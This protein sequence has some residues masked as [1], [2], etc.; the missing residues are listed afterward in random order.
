M[1]RSYAQAAADV[2]KWSLSIP[3][4]IVA[5]AGVP[6]SGSLIALLLAQHRNIHFVE[7]EQLL[8]GERPWTERLRRNVTAKPADGPVLVV[9]DTCYTGW[10]IRQLKPSIRGNIRYGALYVGDEGRHELDYWFAVAPVW[11]HS[12]EWNLLHDAPT[13]HV[14]SDLDG[15]LCEDYLLPGEDHD[16]SEAYAKHLQ[17]ARKIRG[18]SYPVHAVV[19][20]RLEKYR[21]QTEDWLGRSGILYD[22]LIMCP[23][24]TPDE[25]SRMGFGRWKAS[26]YAELPDARLFVENDHSQAKTI[27]DLTGKAV[28]S[29]DR[30]QIIGGVDPVENPSVDSDA[31]IR[32]GVRINLGCGR[33]RIAGYV[34]VDLYC[35][36]DVVADLCQFEPSAKAADVLAVHVM[37]HLSK[38][39]AEAALCKIRNY[40]TDGGRLV[41]EMP[42]REK[43][44]TLTRSYDKALWSQGV[45]GI[46]GDRVTTSGNLDHGFI[47]WRE[48]HRA[49][50]VQRVDA[51]DFDGLCC[52]ASEF[53]RPG[54]EHRYL[55]SAGE[56]R[57]ALQSAGFGTV[58]VEAPIH[59]GRRVHRDTRWV[60]TA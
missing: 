54:Q 21:Q 57:A 39:D 11:S 30:M 60:A 13:K 34:N 46:M 8:R 18:T 9:D 55:W 19:T 6:R 42:D 25:R 12:F 40:L 36:A 15:T 26:V 52:L 4:D 29:I 5:V 44:L 56:F 22:R 20:A 1:F 23:A 43:C 58:I 28:L 14:C 27:Y 41:V 49:D 38:R 7:W 37:E 10:T 50:I 35:P 31:A 48:S 2:R 59:H 45:L 3:D 33:K 51:L 16:F 32:R 47:R 53:H 17:H 24:V